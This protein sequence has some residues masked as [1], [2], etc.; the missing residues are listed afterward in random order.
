MFPAV[1]SQTVAPVCSEGWAV[2]AIGQLG[3]GN[4]S[5]YGPMLETIKH[6]LPMA[7]AQRNWGF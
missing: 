4:A 5:N 2:E 3:A 7:D 1:H 6:V